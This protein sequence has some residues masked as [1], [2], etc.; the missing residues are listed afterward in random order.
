[1]EK[2]VAAY[3]QRIILRET[4]EQ[5][6]YTDLNALEQTLKEHTGV[7][8]AKCCVVYGKDNLFQIKAVVK[9]SE[10]PDVNELLL[11]QVNISFPI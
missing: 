11:R 4:L 7:S 1:M 5:R 2:S 6:S 3:R 9:A 10:K 8:D